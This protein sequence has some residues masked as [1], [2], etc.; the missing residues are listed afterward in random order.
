MADKPYDQRDLEER[1]T[2]VY[3]ARGSGK[4]PYT[5]DTRA[6]HCTCMAYA[7]NRNQKGI[8]WCKHLTA[9]FALEGRPQ[10]GPTPGGTTKQSPV[11]SNKPKPKAQPTQTPAQRREQKKKEEEQ[12]QAAMD[13]QKIRMREQL[14]R[15]LEQLRQDV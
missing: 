5:V 7:M 1:G 12:E 13:F 4:T 9:A 14:R 2:G 10:S 15:E 6:E 8:E 11:Q 3:T